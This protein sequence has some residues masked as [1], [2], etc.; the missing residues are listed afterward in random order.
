MKQIIK[1]AIADSPADYTEIRIERRWLNRV[2]FQREKLETLE[3]ATEL[4]GVVRCLKSGG[5]GISVFNDL[6][7]LSKHVE[8]AAAMAGVVAAATID[9]VVLVDVPVVEDE[10]HVELE[11]D[12]RDV[13]L[14]RKVELAQSY[15]GI[16]LGESD[17]IAST[18]VQYVDRFAEITFANS[19]G[20]YLVQEIPDIT[21]LLGAAASDGKGDIQQGMETIG[22]AGGFEW[23]EGMEDQAQVAAK[24]AVA[25]L[26]AE[27][28]DGGQHTVILDPR[29]A[30]VFIHE[31]FG[32]FCEAD[33]LYKNPRLA[34][35]MTLGNEFGSADLQ[36]VDKG[37]IPG[38]RG[39][40]PYDDEGVRR[41]KTYLIKDGRLH[42]LIHSRETAAKMG[43]EPTGNARAVSY[44][45]EPIVRMTNTYIENGT[46]SFEDMIKGVEHGIYAVDAYGGQTEFEQFSFSAAYAYEI[47]NGEVGGLLRNVVL[48]GNLFETMRSIDAIGT[49]LKVSGGVGGCGKGGQFPLPVTTGAPHIRIRNVTIGGK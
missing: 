4:G 49:D 20:T 29:L 28:V 14:Q 38:G 9:P 8:E 13:P 6:T 25:M 39:N 22:Q 11:H 26:D 31:A 30:G 15:N 10:V 41:E 36:V 5:W 17:K 19:E 16:I 27:P 37:F 42:S 35:I 1:Q 18:M 45:Y 7:N 47:V 2:L 40:V 34:E 21:L 48:S 23:V 24:R 33:F 12:F 44:E 32:H 3:S 43:A 46:S